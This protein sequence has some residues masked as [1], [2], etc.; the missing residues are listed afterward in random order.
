MPYEGRQVLIFFDIKNFYLFL[1]CICIF[2][3]KGHTTESYLDFEYFLLIQ[4][5]TKAKLQNFAKSK[6]FARTAH[7]KFIFC[8]VHCITMTY[9]SIVILKVRSQS[10]AMQLR[11]RCINYLSTAAHCNILHIKFTSF[12]VPQCSSHAETEIR[13]LQLAT[14]Q[15]QQT[16]N[17]ALDSREH[18]F[19]TL[20]TYSNVVHIYVQLAYAQ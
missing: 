13:P 4:F 2:C 19:T 1:K 17:A 15:L 7:C 12:A 10:A 5:G 11:Y 9:N 3:V 18:L 14:M 16:M 6:I 20:T 8:E